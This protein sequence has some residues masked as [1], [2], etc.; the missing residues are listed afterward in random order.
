ML[1]SDIIS[2]YQYRCHGMLSILMSW[3][4]RHDEVMINYTMSWVYRCHVFCMLSLIDVMPMSC[5]NRYRFYVWYCSWVV[6]SHYL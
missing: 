1:L 2:Y 5:S 6:V 3:C 4:Y